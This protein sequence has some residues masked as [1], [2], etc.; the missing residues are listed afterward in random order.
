MNE[1]MCVSALVLII[2]ML[3]TKVLYRFRVP[4]LLIFIIL[5]MVFGSDGLIGFY[6]DNFELAGNLCSLGLIFIMFYGG[7][8]VNWNLAKPVAIFKTKREA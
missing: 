1:M 5:G 4:M 6:F 8:G 2:C 7:F 3:A